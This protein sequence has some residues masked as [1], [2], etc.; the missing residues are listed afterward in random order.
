MGRRRIEVCQRCAEKRGVRRHG[1]PQ[2]LSYQCRTESRSHDSSGKA[3]DGKSLWE[4]LER[5]SALHD[6]CQIDYGNDDRCS[7]SEKEMNEEHLFLDTIVYEEIEICKIDNGE[8]ESD[9][10]HGL[11]SPL[12]KRERVIRER[13]ARDYACEYI[14][15]EV[16]K[17]CLVKTEYR[18]CVGMFENV[19]C[20][21]QGEEDKI[22]ER[23]FH[24]VAVCQGRKRDVW[25]VQ[26][27]GS[28]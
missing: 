14:P 27:G 6:R 11:V 3:V 4:H 19:F 2:K 9:S 7:T 15:V 23:G 12:A 26:E 17:V 25:M 10:S 20:G 16:D 13:A 22:D 5:Q 8:S 1:A 18:G 21:K 24:N 28:P